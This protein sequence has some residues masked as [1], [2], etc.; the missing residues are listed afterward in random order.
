VTRYYDI[1][2]SDTLNGPPITV[3]SLAFG[4]PG[5]PA[6]WTSHPNGKFDPA[7]QEV[8]FDFAVLPHGQPTQNGAFLRIWGVDLGTMQRASIFGPQ[9]GTGAPGKYIRMLGG[10]QAG[11]P[12]A[13]PAQAGMLLQGR[14]WQSYGNWRGTDQTL[15]LL[16]LNAPATLTAPTNIAFTWEKGA[17]LASAL[18]SVLSVAFPGMKQQIA[19]SPQIVAQAREVGVYSSTNEL[20][21]FLLS[22]TKSIGAGAI[23]NYPG[24]SLVAQNG[25]IRASDGTEVQTPKQIVFTD[26]IGQPTWLGGDQNFGVISV[27]T[28]LR[29]DIQAF[30]T[31]KLPPEL[32]QTGS[33][34]L[35]QPN[36][37][38][39]FRNASAIQGSF[40]VQSIRH[41]GKS[42]SPDGTQWSSTF[43]CVSLIAGVPSK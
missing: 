16:V 12:L 11:L 1:T 19:I 24:V 15:D 33:Y 6:R 27:Q 39:N 30:D 32:S 5:T 26:L 14:V 37:F 43:N 8:E 3:P 17:T 31:I 23:P 42:R 13:N 28:V 2:I 4:Q 25:T 29:A 7:A 20:A 38:A 40:F 36:S 22:I 35:N 34:V 18:P 41:L 9:P 21:Q 10:M